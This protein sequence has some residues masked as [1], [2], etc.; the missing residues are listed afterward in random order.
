MDRQRYALIFGPIIGLIIFYLLFTTM[1]DRLR[2]DQDAL[3]ELGPVTMQEV[4]QNPALLADE[5][6]AVEGEEVVAE[7]V[8]EVAAEVAG[9]EEPSEADD[10]TDEDAAMTEGMSGEAVAD[11]AAT[12]EETTDGEA[13][14]DESSSEE[15]TDEA[16]VAD[17]TTDETEVVDDQTVGAVAALE[18]DEADSSAVLT[19][20]TVVTATEEGVII[21]TVTDTVRILGG[22]YVAE[23]IVWYAQEYI[24]SN[25]EMAETAADSAIT[26]LFNSGTISGSTTC[27]NYTGRYS[28]DPEG[29]FMVE[30]TAIAPASATREECSGGGVLAI[31]EA[32][33]LAALARAVTFEST[34]SSMDVSDADGNLLIHYEVV[35]T[36]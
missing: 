33:Y 21:A 7:V 32:D 24:D 27:S 11:E 25:G 29:I 14:E 16:P 28:V 17:E 9:M 6:D 13:I 20:S 4:T 1:S 35:E 22:A 2:A 3:R 18:T 30:L 34:E 23:N 26:A 5:A 19:D 15:T 12:D 10:A 36:E 8:A 31:Q